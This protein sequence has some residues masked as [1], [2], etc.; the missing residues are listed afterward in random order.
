M[1][2]DKK[3]NIVTLYKPVNETE[4]SILS[5][6]LEKENIH[7][8]VKNDNVQDLFGYGRIGT[9]YNILTGPIIMQVDKK[10]YSAAL[11]VIQNYS[12]KI[13][14]STEEDPDLKLIAQF[15]HNLNLSI[16]LGLF[17]PGMG[18]FPLV[19]AVRMKIKY[20]EDLKGTLKL[21]VSCFITLMGFCLL[22]FLF[23][24]WL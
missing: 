9:G 12:L 8:Y 4:F 10:D 23:K 16:I 6:L 21:L 7:F 1:T 5:S 22:Y 17:L 3:L 13:H 18:I 19:N 11:K 14:T 15:R 20:K 24:S 2:M